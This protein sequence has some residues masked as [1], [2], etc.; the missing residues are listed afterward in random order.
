MD[1][2]NVGQISPNE[3]A[4]FQAAFDLNMTNRLA[5]N[6]VIKNGQID[7]ILRHDRFQHLNHEYSVR[8]DSERRPIT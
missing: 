3:I 6:T 7:S 5:Q 4:W 8:I 2:M 1:A